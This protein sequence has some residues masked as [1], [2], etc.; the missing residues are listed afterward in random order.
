MTP[1]PTLTPGGPEIGAPVA[2][3]NPA[4]GD[5]TRIHFTL[6]QPGEIR[7][8]LFTAAFRK[9]LERPMGNLPAGI[10]D[11]ELE[12]KDQGGAPL[13]NGIYYLVVANGSKRSVGKL[14]ISK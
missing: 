5:H 2:Y 3:P 1:S 7:F 8:Q 10:Q 6:G 12:L 9:V 13:A 4:S 14:L 11:F